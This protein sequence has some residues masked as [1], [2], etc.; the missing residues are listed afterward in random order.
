MLADLST[1]DQKIQFEDDRKV[2][3]EQGTSSGTGSYQ[4]PTSQ[5][6]P[7]LGTEEP[8]R[9]LSFGLNPRRAISAQTNAHEENQNSSVSEMSSSRS[10]WSWVEDEGAWEVEGSKVTKCEG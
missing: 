9:R 4:S 6:L 8:M 3:I 10:E 2:D 5:M 1:L 7:M